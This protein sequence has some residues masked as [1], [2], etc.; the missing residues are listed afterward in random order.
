MFFFCLFF[1]GGI[2]ATWQENKEG[3]KGLERVFFGGKKWAKRGK[4]R[5]IKVEPY[6]EISFQQVAKLEEES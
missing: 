4:A 3:A 1:W 2:F 5:P 6:L